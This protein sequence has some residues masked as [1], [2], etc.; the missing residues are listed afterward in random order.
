[1]K[2]IC[3]LLAVAAIASLAIVG[4]QAGTGK[5]SKPHSAVRPHPETTAT[6]AIRANWARITK[7]LEARN[8][9]RPSAESVHHISKNHKLFDATAPYGGAYGVDV[10]SFQGESTWS[11]L[12]SSGYSFG[13]VREF[14]EGCS[15]DG[16]GVHTVANAWAAGVAHVDIYL[17]PSYG[18]GV[19]AASQVDATIDS[20][21]SIPFGTLW[22]DIETGGQGAPS[23]NDNWMQQAVQQAVARIGGSRIGIYSSRY[24]WSQVMG[25]AAD[26]YSF[27]LWYP[28][29]DGEPSFDSFSS[30]AGW[31][32]PAMKQF[33]GDASVCGADVDLNWY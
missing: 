27:P 16:N 28:D 20:M 33:Q 6:P 4:V 9:T 15:V 18:C 7:E 31:S 2:S 25:N 21:G 19:S 10:S 3:R 30:F 23:D 13:I 1:M 5:L 14:T 8:Y 11:C 24:E 32:S 17:F 29:Y 22:F 26:L 12:T